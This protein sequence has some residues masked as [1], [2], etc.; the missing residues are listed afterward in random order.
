MEKRKETLNKWGNVLAAL[1]PGT[2]YSYTI[3]KRKIDESEFRDSR[4]IQLCNDEYDEYRGEYNNMLLKKNEKAARLSEECFFQ[5]NTIQ[6]DEE[7]AARFLNRSRRDVNKELS[8]IGSSLYEV[9]AEEYL[10]IIYNFLNMEDIDFFKEIDIDKFLKAKHGPNDLITPFKT[11]V[12]ADY[13]KIGNKYMR[14]LYIPPSGFAT[15]IDDDVVFDLTEKDIHLSLSTHILPLPTDEAQDL[16]DSNAMKV[17]N[18]IEKFQQSQNKHGNYSAMLPFAMRKDRENQEEWNEDINQRDQRV[19][20]TF[21]SMVVVADSIEELDEVTA[22]LET[23]ARKKGCKLVSLTLEQKKGLITALPFG[24]NRFLSENGEKLRT[25]TTENLST[26]IPFTVQ[27]VNHKGGIYYGQNAISGRSIFI[28]RKIGMNSNCMVYGGSGAGKSFK[29][30]ME[31]IFTIL[32][33]EDKLII[34]DP[35]R[36]YGKVV[37]AFGGQVIKMSPGSDVH[38]NALEMEKEYGDTKN[39]ITTKSE[40]MMSLYAAIKETDKI[41]SKEKTI[42]DACVQEVYKEYIDSGYTI[43]P[44]TLVDFVRELKN[45]DHPIAEDMALAFGIFTTGSLNTFAKPTNVDMSNRIICFDTYELGSHLQPVGMLVIT[46]YIL[47]TLIK[48][49]AAGTWTYVDVDEIYLM[50]RYAATAEFFFRLA[51]RIRKY[52]GL[53]TGITQ[54]VEDALSTETGRAMM[55]N[56]EFCIFLSLSSEEAAAVAEILRLTEEQLEYVREVEP[57][58]GIIK[59]GNS[60]IPFEDKFPLNTKLYKLMSTKLEK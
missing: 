6:K 52:N 47:N 51:K 22:E 50:Y 39:P 28:N 45:Y 3:M 53:L 37:E 36:E 35:E 4:L 26:F 27:E 40:F 23:I 25:L 19:F 49:R 38:I 56:S 14:S 18:N 32:N 9:S 54:Q 20:L 7:S 12:F 43:E 55:S 10:E 57:G 42:I 30:K 46:D 41:D 15:Y 60:I 33:S 29:K 5:V 31:Q 44:P 2:C 13:I 8:T 24:C 34:I 16:V 48:N 11:E 58:H 1:E 21:I 59:L 17:E